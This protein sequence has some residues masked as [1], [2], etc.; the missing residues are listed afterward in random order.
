MQAGNTRTSNIAAVSM[1]SASQFRRN[2]TFVKTSAYE[3]TVKPALDKLN[4]TDKTAKTAI[5]L[6]GMLFNCSD[7]ISIMVQMNSMIL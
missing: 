2:A 5:T 6:C 7:L 1:T 4:A 3:E